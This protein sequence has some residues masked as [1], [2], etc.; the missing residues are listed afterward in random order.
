V[1]ILYDKIQMYD[2]A[3]EAMVCVS[4]ANLDRIRP[5]KLANSDLD[6]MIDG[7]KARIQEEE[8]K[9]E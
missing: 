5:N 7:E 9:F 6:M 3:L 8:Q 2:E 1:V 4:L